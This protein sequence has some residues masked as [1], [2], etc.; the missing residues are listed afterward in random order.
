MELAGLTGVHPS[1]QIIFILHFNIL[2]AG[3][4]FM[5]LS[6]AIFFQNQVFIRISFRNIFWVSNSRDPDQAQQNV[7]P[8][9]GPNCLQKLPA[10][11]NSR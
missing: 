3:F 10:D 1:L 11:N 2:H 6:S 9:Q 7:G 8:D 4:F 5:T